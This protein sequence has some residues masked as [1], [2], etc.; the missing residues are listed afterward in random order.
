MSRS[1]YLILFAALTVVLAGMFAG[2]ETGVYRLSRLRL[3]LA[4]ERKQWLFVLLGNVMHDS[5]G[6]LLSLLIGTNLSHYLATSFITSMFLEIVDS[7]R[8]AEILTTIMTVP[9]L[10]VFSELIPKN[11][12]LYRAETLTSLAAPFL[13]FSHK[14]FTYCGAVPLLRLLSQAFSRL[15]GSSAS[16]R[17]IMTSAQSH[18]VRAILHDTHE[19]GILSP[20]QSDIID[21]IVNIP[22]L[23]LNA[24]MVPL[25]DVQSVDIQELRFGFE[26]EIVAKVAQKG[27]RIFEVGVSYSGRTYEE[28]K[29]I[30]WKDGVRAMY[31]I[32]R[33]NLFS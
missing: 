15:I 9:I 30:N 1:L 26:I 7:E 31:C 29:K 12:F 18:H 10:F 28:G 33:Y 3:R 22:G 8:T 20:I 17:T 27:Y 6:I 21:R 5:S 32:V 24:V 23:R 2:A 14:L 25:T 16:S 4:V 13:F 11:V 19:E